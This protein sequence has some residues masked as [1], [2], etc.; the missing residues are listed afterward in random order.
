MLAA[1]AV[2][3]LLA[4]LI[5]YGVYRYY[6]TATVAKEA[7]L[8][9]VAGT[10]RIA[11]QGAADDV[12]ADSGA[13]ILEGFTIKTDNTS[14]A[15]LTLFDGST[16][17]IFENTELQVKSLRTSR[18]TH[19]ITLV[20]LAES[21][22]RIRVG[23]APTT[24]GVSRFQ[25]DTPHAV[26]VLKDG[27]YSIEVAPQLSMISVRTGASEVTALK[28]T[29]AVNRGE[30]SSVVAGQPPALPQPAALD[31]VLNG[32]F[33]QRDIGWTQ[34][35]EVEAGR[36]DDIVGQTLFV[37]DSDGMSV[38]FVRR[39]SKN[40]HGENSVFQAINR[41]VSDFVSLKLSVDVR[42]IYQSLSGGGYLGSEY[43]VVVRITY[44][45]AEGNQVTW[46]RGF[47]YQNDAGYPTTYGEQ[48]PADVWIPFEKDLL[49]L[50]GYPKPFRLL[51]I[52]VMASGWDYES[53]IRSI[54]ILAE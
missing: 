40:S 19:G 51:S 7:T 48:A 24:T 4:I 44:R 3:L 25:V 49:A 53:M 9:V 52:E 1:F 18:F 17:Y 14:R 35:N 26:M 2:F 41:D 33:R 47:Y 31:L 50:E 10:V 21:K 45:D 12:A 32:D 20:S 11:R 23:V 6:V 37:G 16:I 28:S 22:G 15:L 43:P 29:V 30:R 54:S 27:S 36:R 46:A 34:R 13:P 5:P 42:L 38:R 8:E 39:G